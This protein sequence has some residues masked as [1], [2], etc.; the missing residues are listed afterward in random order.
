MLLPRGGD[1]ETF[2]LCPMG[3]TR[4]RVLLPFV[5]CVDQV[6]IELLRVILG[7]FGIRL[8]GFRVRPLLLLP[9]IVD[10]LEEP[11]GALP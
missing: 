8:F 4:S 1:G 9:K 5:V 2:D 10:A 3:T 11:S 6:L 7:G